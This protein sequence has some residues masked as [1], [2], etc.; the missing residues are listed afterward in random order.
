MNI[1]HRSIFLKEI[2]ELYPEL[3][4][5]LNEQDGM[6]YFE[7]DVFLKFVQKCIDECKHKNTR[8]LIGQVNRYYQNG[9]KAL[10]ELIRNGICENVKFEDSKKTSR[11]WALEYLCPSLR[12]ERADWLSTMGPP[13]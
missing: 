4:K 3:R 9:D 12:K 1:I 7:V 2:T 8:I 13:R 10:N 11:S 5:K 6:L